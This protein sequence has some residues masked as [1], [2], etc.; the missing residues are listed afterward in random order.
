M[1]GYT[2]F[3]TQN[4][5]FIGSCKGMFGKANRIVEDDYRYK[6]P[7]IYYIDPC[8]LCNLKCPFCIT[9]YSQ[10]HHERGVMTLTDFK[11]VVEKISS[12]ADE[13]R[14]FN[15]GEPFLNK[16]ILP[17]IKFASE[18]SLKVS[19]CSNLSFRVFDNN[20]A[21]DVVKSGLSE[22][23][24]SIDGASQLT[25]GK[26]RVGG[27]YDVVINNIKEIQKAKRKL[28]SRYPIIIWQFLI[29]GY[30]EHEI[31][32][33]IKV[34]KQLSIELLFGPMFVQQHPEWL[35]SYHNNSNK[36][37]LLYFITSVIFNRWKEYF[38]A[39]KNGM[40]LRKHL[41]RK[42]P[43]WCIQVYDSMIINW[44]GNVFPCCTIYDDRMSMG[45]IINE[46]LEE[47]WNG[48]KFRRCREYIYNYDKELSCDSRCEM[49]LCP[50]VPRIK[51]GP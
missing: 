36:V 41:S 30:N 11:I 42:L 4:L 27:N 31:V 32:K 14:L 18:L 49:G 17:M 40:Y 46:S 22:L 35:S 2:N 12:H 43:G 1:A 29:N 8:N 9:S 7:K 16:N 20:Y 33:A 5:A 21:E 26:Y 24:V 10:E 47:I 45:N 38:A 51:P 48:D 15:W 34:A 50:V 19:T 39:I 6:F 23:T 44:D 37:K 3:L 28:K 25:Y 13:V